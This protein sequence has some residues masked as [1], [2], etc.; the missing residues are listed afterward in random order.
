MP[1]ASLLRT[2]LALALLGG[3]TIGQGDEDPDHELGFGA[4]MSNAPRVTIDR[5]KPVFMLIERDKR[6]HGLKPFQDLV[7]KA[8]PG[9]VLRPLP[10]GRL[11]PF[12][13][14]RR[15]SFGPVCTRALRQCCPGLR[16]ARVE[17]EPASSNSFSV[18]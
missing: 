2:V 10:A 14:G 1:S 6:I 4:D 9:S 5:P 18:A 16:L 15:P 13:C 17:A 12:P 11:P 7:D 8:A 3:A